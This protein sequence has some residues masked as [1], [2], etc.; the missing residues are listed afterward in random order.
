MLSPDFP[1]D[2]TEMTWR[3]GARPLL[4]H[5][6][7]VA[8]HADG[9]AAEV[10]V[11]DPCTRAILKGAVAPVTVAELAARVGAPVSAVRCV[12]QR[13]I[14]AG[15]MRVDSHGDEGIASGTVK[16]V[17]AAATLET[18][19]SF[20]AAVGEPI[21]MRVRIPVA[22]RETATIESFFG[23][24]IIRGEGLS[25]FMAGSPKHWNFRPL[26]DDEIRGALGMVI[27]ADPRFPDAAE[28]ALASCHQH[29]LPHVLVAEHGPGLR[30]VTSAAR[31]WARY[32]LQ[33]T[34]GTPVLACDVRDH[35]SVTGVL[36]ALVGHARTLTSEATS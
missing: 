6:V 11:P 24:T 4:A 30:V 3:W 8:T 13:L 33:I 12:V 23:R 17:V 10:A 34:P 35:D 28:V 2:A 15:F 31:H 29:G 26:W 36:R 22:P 18:E 19:R 5:A 25:I 21:P 16:V 1:L 14:S 7:V 9:P 32:A 20:I 27:L